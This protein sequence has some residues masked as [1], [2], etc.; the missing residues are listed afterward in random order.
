MLAELKFPTK[1]RSGAPDECGVGII[2]GTGM[3][4][5]Y[6]HHEFVCSFSPN[7]ARSVARRMLEM[8]DLV[9]PT[10]PEPAPAKESA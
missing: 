7:L 6:A 10:T 3:V 5:L 4:A 9:D 1:T 2:I 8:A